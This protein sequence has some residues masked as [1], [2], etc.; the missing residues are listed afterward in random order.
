MRLRLALSMRVV[1]ASGYHEP[2][3][4]IAQDWGNFLRTTLPDAVWLGMPN[5]GPTVVET[6]EEFGINGLILTGGEDWGVSPERDATEEAALRWAM[7]RKIPVLG[8]C[9]GAQVINLCLGG[10][11]ERLEDERHVATRHPVHL[12]DGSVVTVN[13]YHHQ[14]IP[15][16]G[17]APDLRPTANDQNGAVE[18]FIHTSLP[19][20]GVVWHP[21]RESALSNYDAALFR[22]CFAEETST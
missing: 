13:S 16:D 12:D 18:G 2:R 3:D 4:A 6:L 5:L 14:V 1:H 10:R 9:R 7:G 15:A 11:L 21:E 17:L 19:I 8:V 22:R 20:A